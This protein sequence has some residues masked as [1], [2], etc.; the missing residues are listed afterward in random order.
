MS[1][2]TFVRQRNRRNLPGRPFAWFFGEKQKRMERVFSQ[3]FHSSALY[4]PYSGATTGIHC[5]ERPAA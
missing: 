3:A 1:T 5:R 2:T 4:H